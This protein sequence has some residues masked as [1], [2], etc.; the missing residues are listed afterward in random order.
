MGAG[1]ISLRNKFI[2][3]VLGSNRRLETPCGYDATRLA[4]ADK[5]NGGATCE[6]EER[7]SDSS[8]GDTGRDWD[9]LI[10]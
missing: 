7:D 6:L 2:S 3:T 5:T 9:G 10:G 1:N 4:A 8:G